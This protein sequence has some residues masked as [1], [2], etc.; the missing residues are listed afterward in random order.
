MTVKKN[1]PSEEQSSTSARTANQPLLPTGLFSTKHE[2]LDTAVPV[3]TI[4][5]VKQLADII[6]PLPGCEGED[7][8]TVAIALAELIKVLTG[9]ARY[10]EG[11][12]GDWF[13]YWAARYA[14]ERTGSFESALEKW[15]MN[16]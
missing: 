10:A 4:E 1:T 3:A 7:S 16:A 9:K 6:V 12:D 2:R 8:D 5:R 11:E 13:A 15:K 14:F